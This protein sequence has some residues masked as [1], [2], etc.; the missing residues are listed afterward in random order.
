MAIKVTCWQCQLLNSHVNCHLRRAKEIQIRIQATDTVATVAKKAARNHQ[1]AHETCQGKQKEEINGESTTERNKTIS[2]EN[3]SMI[4]RHKCKCKSRSKRQRPFACQKYQ[5]Y[6][7]GKP[8]IPCSP[9]PPPRLLGLLIELALTFAGSIGCLQRGHWDGQTIA[10][11]HWQIQILWRLRART[12][13]IR[14]L[15]ATSRRR[16]DACMATSAASSN[17]ALTGHSCA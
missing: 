5:K 8:A 2:V 14:N 4:A 16:A 6:L 10:R 1:T 17:Q 15:A 12:R 11:R 3:I 7:K 13:R 9:A